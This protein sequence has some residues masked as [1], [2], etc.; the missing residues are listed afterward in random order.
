MWQGMKK[1]IFVVDDS[2]TN[3]AIAK[4]VLEKQYKV[5]TV[6]SGDKLFA[7][8]E[9]FRPDLILLDIEM[10]V[11]NGFEILEKLKTSE[12]LSK[13][14]VIFLTS[15]KDSKVEVR[16]LEMGII[17]FISKPFSGPVLLN[18]VRVHLEVDAIIRERTAQAENMHY[19]MLFV[20]ADLVESRDEKTGGHIW[21]VTQFTKA[22]RDAMLEDDIYTNELELIDDKTID[23][24]G[25]LHDIGKI[26]IPDEVLKKTG[27]LT[28]SE[29]EIMRTHPVK[30]EII[31]ETMI[32]RTGANKML[33]SIKNFTAYHHEKWD[34][35]GYPNGLKGLDIPIQGR[36]MGVADFYDI[37]TSNRGPQGA[38]SDEEAMEIMTHEV[39]TY[40]DPAIGRVF[41]QVADK[42]AQIRKSWKADDVLPDLEFPEFKL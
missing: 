38:L 19:N 25:A 30:G 33:S 17:D 13:I 26:S 5:M 29:F 40:F 21:R 24:A 37:L 42:F 20:L 3:L 4:Q 35:T 36:I 1:M 8:L 34:G 18:R 7:L 16:G 10:P 23:G 6:S 9:K 22:L 41:P 28:P 11:M 31:V 32:A 39:G 27:V 12:T 2:D 14:P 15:L